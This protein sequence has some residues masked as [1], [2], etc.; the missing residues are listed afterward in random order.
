MC[1]LHGLTL[2]LVAD[3][4]DPTEEKPYTNVIK[5]ICIRVTPSKSTTFASIKNIKL[6]GGRPYAVL[7]EIKAKSKQLN[8]SSE[9]VMRETLLNSLPENIQGIL[10]P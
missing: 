10:I 1:H 5:A 6:N 2:E 7:A 3:K 4:L 8:I 9:D